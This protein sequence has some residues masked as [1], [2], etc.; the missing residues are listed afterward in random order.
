MEPSSWVTLVYR[1]PHPPREVTSLPGSS[2]LLRE[3][4]P[5]PGPWMPSFVLIS[6]KNK[7]QTIWHFL[8]QCQFLKKDC[9][10]ITA[11]KKER[12]VLYRTPRQVWTWKQNEDRWRG[13]GVC[14]SSRQLLGGT[15]LTTCQLLPMH[16][17]RQWGSVVSY[18]QEHFQ[19]ALLEAAICQVPTP[20]PAM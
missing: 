20:L 12:E 13:R 11:R 16:V 14:V 9:K 10:V 8:A 3:L 19:S 7:D 2:E 1:P 15:L 17:G 5:N 4:S 6:L 18:P